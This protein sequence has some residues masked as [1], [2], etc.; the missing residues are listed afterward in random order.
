MN[1][2]GAIYIGGLS[3]SGKTQLRLLLMQRPGILITRRTYMWPR[4]DGRYGDLGRDENLA[5]CL[6]AMLAAPGIRA[7]EPDR[8]RI[9]RE[10]RSGP[11]TYARL[12]ALFHAHHARRRDA[13]R[14]GDQLGGI[15]QYAAP[16]LAADPAARIIHMV[17]DPRERLAELLGTGR[18]PGMAGW[19]TQQWRRS[20]GLALVHRERFP[21]RYRI[22]CYEDLS[23]DTARI[24]GEVWAFLGEG[25]ALHPSPDTVSWGSETP[26]AANARL[27][28]YVER[29][30]AAEMAD[31]G[32][33]PARPAL[34]P[35][36]R[37][38]LNFIDAP[39][40]RIGLEVR[41]FRQPGDLVVPDWTA[42]SRG[43]AVHG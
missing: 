32:Y 26:S 10:F 16:I 28:A 4:Y 27:I 38:L 2:A 22:V 20:A 3:Y 31:L 13:R 9:E 8:G 30:A 34:G 17:R 35:R 39:L 43:V 15:E 25:D 37:L 29:H 14:W 33:I 6:D 1:D 5:R 42:R 19:E 12:F 23:R 21:G 24:M 11:P 18:R 40:N 41:R 36:E 7:L